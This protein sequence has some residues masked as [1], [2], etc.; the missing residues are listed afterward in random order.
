MSEQKTLEIAK[1]SNEIWN[2]NLWYRQLDQEAKDAVALTV[3]LMR[4]HAHVKAPLRLSVFFR[5]EITKM[6]DAWKSR[7]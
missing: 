4:N 7:T 1:I 2:D 5:A 3:W 6:I